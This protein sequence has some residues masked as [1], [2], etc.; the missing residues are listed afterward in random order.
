MVKP[1]FKTHDEFGTIE[2]LDDGSKRILSFGS[3]HEQS[4][5][6]RDSPQ[7]P[8]HEYARAMML[9]LLLCQPQRICLLGLGGGSLANAILHALADCE[10]HA[11]ELR[12]AVIKVAHRYFQ[13]PRS[14]R[15]H[16]H[17]CDAQEFI[18]QNA[19]CFDLVMVDLYH[20]EGLDML[21]LLPS[22]IAGCT[23]AL[24]EDG[25]LVLNY[26]QEHD[27]EYELTQ[28]LQRD[29]GCVY[30]C[31]CGGGNRI[32]YAGKMP[33]ANNFLAPDTLKSLA[34]TLGYS[35]NHYAKRLQEFPAGPKSNE[36]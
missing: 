28:Q 15:L 30:A 20:D 2:V 29:F 13:L 9:V 26:W 19:L 8:Q 1:V 3:G 6:L 33:P 34:G 25:Y 18:D 31:N 21:Q 16:I 5:Q 10:L 14:S 32:I 35:V 12:K 23:D 4:L 36:L 24:S 17:H 22:F 27:L 11:V 7:V